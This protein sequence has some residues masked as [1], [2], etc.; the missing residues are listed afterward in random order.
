MKLKPII[1]AIALTGMTGMTQAATA[2]ETSAE[3]ERSAWTGLVVGAVAGGPAGAFAGSLIGG[4]V[5]GRL[6]EGRRINRELMAEVSSLEK[7]MEEDKAAYATSVAA[8]NRDLD[9][10]LALQASTAKSQRLP[11]QFRTGSADIESQYEGELEN[12]ARVLRRNRDA[13][14]NL[15]GF[16][17]RRGDTSFNQQLS[18]DRVDAVQAFLLKAG[19]KRDQIISTAYG[20]SQ[21]LHLAETLENNFF[22]RRVLLEMNIDIDPQLATR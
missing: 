1:A 4:E 18:E 5:F 3:K 2:A 15:T 14:I 22:D 11:I 20:E 10:M 21:P 17:D 9:K 7:K 13:R 6:F 19:V 12:I 16:S 8:L